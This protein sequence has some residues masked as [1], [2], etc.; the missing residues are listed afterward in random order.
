MNSVQRIAKNA[1][2]LLLSKLASRLLAFFYIMYTARYLGA[3]GFGILSFALA[4][5]GILGILTDLGLVQLTIREVAR[6]RSLSGIYVSNVFVIKGI[7][8]TLTFGA[9]ILIVHLQN[10]PMET[11]WV[12][13]LIA[14][15]VIFDT[16]TS[17]SGAIF[18]AFERMEYVSF[19]ETLKGMLIFSGVVLAI[20][21]RFHLIG[22][23]SLF[24]FSSMIVL[25]ISILILKSNF[26]GLNQVV[27][28]WKRTVNWQRWKQ[29]LREALPFGL[30]TI[31]VTIYFWID[32]VM[33]SVMKG[34]EVVGWYN[35]AYRLIFGLMLIPLVFT[36][37]IF[38]VMSRHFR[39]AKDAL[40]M[41]YEFTLR[42]LFAAAIYIFVFG[43][44]F[45][46][47]IIVTLYGNSYLPSIN[48]LRILIWV[49]PV[50]F[51]T[52]LFGNL[53]AAVDKQRIVTLVAGANAGL[54]IILN[55]ALIP[56]F[57][58]I[59]ASVATVLTEV[60]GFALMG[61]YISRHIARISVS[62]N[63]LKPICCGTV[64]AF[65]LL[66]L[67]H[68]FDWI[69]VGIAGIFIYLFLL[70]A[71]RVISKDD[72]RVLKRALFGRNNDAAS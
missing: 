66:I 71:F 42:Y 10:Y 35:A 1:G 21:E 6:N 36:A 61:R 14:I 43:F 31:F 25:G 22:F 58:F 38:P 67:M 11:A 56:R 28:R 9:I 55:L 50:I 57:S 8:V 27:V 34:N 18:Q 40:S 48:A 54:N 16:F 51:M 29:I 60:L 19:L 46:N 65:F 7:L 44:L 47:R 37:S 23:A 13:Y 59:G 33:L 4:L 41:E 52:Y 20:H 49:I 39:S 62:R 3:L 64:T 63:I 70:L 5:T 32:S 15:S 17:V 45:A 24:L 69:V 12:V 2:V 30:S 72:I 68:W 53:L 26:L